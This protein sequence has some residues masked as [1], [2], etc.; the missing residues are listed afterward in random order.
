MIGKIDVYMDALYESND[1]EFCVGD[2]V[3]LYVGPYRCYGHIQHIGRKDRCETW[4]WVTVTN[5]GEI[6]VREAE[7]AHG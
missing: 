2:S 3:T 6:W 5:G 7:L 1:T 4:Y